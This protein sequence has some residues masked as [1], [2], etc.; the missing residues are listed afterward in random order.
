[1]LN[2][3][4]GFISVELERIGYK[5]LCYHISFY[6]YRTFFVFM[7]SLISINEKQLQINGLHN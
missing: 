1:M 3:S 6:I 2:G 7:F 5:H 4:S